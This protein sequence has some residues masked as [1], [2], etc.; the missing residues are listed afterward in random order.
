VLT[1]ELDDHRSAELDDRR[2]AELETMPRQLLILS[3]CYLRLTAR[4]LVDTTLL[5]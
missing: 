2:S 5:V 3:G 4:A 1:A